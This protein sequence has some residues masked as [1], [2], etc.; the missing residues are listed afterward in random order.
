[1]GQKGTVGGGVMDKLYLFCCVSY[2][3]IHLSK[4]FEL[5]T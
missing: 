3:G 2:L 1:M 5:D 4:L